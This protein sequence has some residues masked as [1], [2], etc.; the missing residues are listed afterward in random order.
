MGSLTLNFNVFYP[1]FID[2][3]ESNFLGLIRFDYEALLKFFMN[4]FSSLA[5]WGVELREMSF[6]DFWSVMPLLRSWLDFETFAEKSF[7]EVDLFGGPGRWS[8]TCWSD[9]VVFR[10][11][12]TNLRPSPK[13]IS[14]CAYIVDSSELKLTSII[15]SCIYD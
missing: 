1:T 3:D 15:F 12:F 8:R 9:D 4:E 13:D 11:F 5:T 2:W 10:F 6:I 7:D 14:E